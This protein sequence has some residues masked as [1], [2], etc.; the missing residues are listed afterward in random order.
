MAGCC[1]LQKS[2]KTE[3]Y[4]PYFKPNW[5]FDT[6]CCTSRPWLRH[7]PWIAATMG[8]RDCSILLNNFWASSQRLVT[9]SLVVQDWSILRAEKENQDKLLTFQ[10]SRVHIIFHPFIDLFFVKYVLVYL[11]FYTYK[12][13]KQ[14]KK[15]HRI[16]HTHQRLWKPSKAYL[17]SAPARKQPGLPEMRTTLFEDL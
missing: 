3:S 11:Y 5:H 1:K 9:S 12:T 6:N 2:Y 16:Y 10:L 17:L 4:C 8:T 7:E 14:N 15:Q 13:N